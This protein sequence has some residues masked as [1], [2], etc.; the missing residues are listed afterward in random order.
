M[1]QSHSKSEILMNDSISQ[2]L[3]DNHCDL[4]SL[5]FLAG[6]ASARTYYRVYKNAEPRVLMVSSEEE[7]K[8]KS[9]VEIAGLLNNHGFHAPE[10]L[11]AD[12]A[13]GLYLL[14]D[15]GDLTFNRALQDD[16]PE[17]ILYE[18]GVLGLIEMHKSFRHNERNIPPYD[19]N[20]FCDEAML[21]LE[22]YVPQVLSD[23][24][25]DAQ[26]AEFYNLWQKLYEAQPQMPQTLALKDYMVDNLIW[27]P[28]EEGIRR[29]G[30]LDF[31]DALWGPITYDL[32]SLLE[33][34]RRDVDPQIVADML[35][36]YLK[37]S[38]HLN[39]DDFYHSYYLWGAQ[40]NTR[41]LG[42]F[43]RLAIRDGKKRY[44]DFIPRTWKLL[45]A[46]LKHAALSELQDWMDENI[47][48]M[49]RVR[50]EC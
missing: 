47:P 50:P 6:D 32:V 28:Q 10:V 37:S 18:L 3:Y 8:N 1:A 48:H 9:F 42:V 13:Q 30:I 29:L 46:D 16:V 5:T 49:C 12:D 26:K 2:F 7:T 44:L 24:L 31:Q 20:R 45:E 36:F 39:G 43:A 23:P 41:I 22:W 4:D 40:R 35:K 33:E 27:I 25:R 15:L 38:P 34:V 17:T 14:E 19:I 21:F 11:A